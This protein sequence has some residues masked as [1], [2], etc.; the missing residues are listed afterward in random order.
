MC[1]G[2][3]VTYAL[4]FLITI[5]MILCVIVSSYDRTLGA[6]SSNSQASNAG[7]ASSNS[8][9][10]TQRRTS[11]RRRSRRGRRTIAATASSNVALD[12]PL[13]V[14]GQR[15][16][17]PTNDN[18]PL[19][20]TESYIKDRMIEYGAQTGYS[21]GEVIKRVEFADCTTPSAAQNNNTVSTLTYGMTLPQAQSSDRCLSWDVVFKE[22][23]ARPTEVTRTTTLR[24]KDLNIDNGAIIRHGVVWVRTAPYRSINIVR[25]DVRTTIVE[26][27]WWIDL[28]DEEVAHRVAR[29]LQHAAQLCR[30]P[31]YV[32]VFIK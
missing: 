32:E 25:P 17:A 9:G 3:S 16:T 12:V 5:Q 21:G 31:G 28:H 13:A 2:R 30:G 29:A 24:L 7:S 8:A 6:S 14:G 27:E 10:A 23:G 20:V 4:A 26:D 18:T 22:G 19:D 15:I 11:A 1:S